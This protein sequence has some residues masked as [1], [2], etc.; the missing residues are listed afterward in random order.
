MSRSG[1]IAIAAIASFGV[2]TALSACTYLATP[3]TARD[4]EVM[5]AS[6]NEIS[7]AVWG[8]TN[9]DKLA[10]THC[11]RFAKK[12][13]FKGAVRAVEYDDVRIVYYECT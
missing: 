5:H 8:W 4:P 6:Q 1:S 13:A 12:A 3:I 9:P 2:L 10:A 7:F 11:G